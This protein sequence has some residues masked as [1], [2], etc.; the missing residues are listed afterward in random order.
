MEKNGFSPIGTNAEQ[1]I[2]LRD[3]GLPKKS[4]DMYLVK[5]WAYEGELKI[6]DKHFDDY[7]EEGCDHIP[8]WSLSRLIDLLP[9]SLNYADD[10]ECMIIFQYSLQIQKDH[11]RYYCD[12]EHPIHFESYGLHTIDAVVDI[13]ILLLKDECWREEIFNQIEELS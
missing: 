5:H 4:A 9:E 10:D 1:S 8:A 13:L 11:V 2:R 7:P 12:E 3:A 6:M